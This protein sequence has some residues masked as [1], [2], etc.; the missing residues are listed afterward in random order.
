MDDLYLSLGALRYTPTYII[1]LITEEK[2][3]MNDLMLEKLKKIIKM[4]LL[5]ME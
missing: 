3:S 2:Q 4:I 1:N 5:L